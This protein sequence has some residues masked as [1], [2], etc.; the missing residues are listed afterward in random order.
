MKTILEEMV[1]NYHPQN[2][3][4]KINCIK[5]SIQE[6]VL[7]GLSKAGFFNI[8]GFYG[9]TALRIFYGLERFSEDLDFTLFEK[10]PNFIFAN[11]LPIL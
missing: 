11:Y 5:E 4:E 1:E 6:I 10:D 2:S 3:E 8:A 9:G 7:Y